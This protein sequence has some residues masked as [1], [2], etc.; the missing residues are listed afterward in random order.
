[1]NI[2]EKRKEKLDEKERNGG[3]GEGCK[4]QHSHNQQQQQQQHSGIQFSLKN[5]NDN[6]TVKGIPY[7]QFLIVHKRILRARQ[8]RF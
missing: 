2:Y 3:W 1:M 6:L 4:G 5:T 7:C 8:W